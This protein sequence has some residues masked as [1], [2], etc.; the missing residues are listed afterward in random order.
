MK[1]CLVFAAAACSIRPTNVIIWVYM[2]SVLLWRLRS[3]NALVLSLV[4]DGITVVC[5]AL[6]RV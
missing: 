2:I 4:F 1:Q 6:L 3:R 5:V